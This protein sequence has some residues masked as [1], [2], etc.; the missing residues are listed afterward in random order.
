MSAARLIDYIASQNDR[1][2]G[3]PWSWNVAVIG[4][5]HGR[6]S[7]DSLGSA[8]KVKTII[9][10]RLKLTGANDADIK[11]LMTRSDATVDLSNRS[12]LMGL[13]WA[14]IK[15]ARSSEYPDGRPLLLLYPIDRESP[16]Q[17][18]KSNRERLNAVSNVLGIG[19][20]FPEAAIPAAVSYVRAPI[21]ASRYEEAEYQEEELDA[22]SS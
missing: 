1:G 15:R 10:A 22:E 13:D 2:N 7:E 11:A 9:R 16:P 5:E 8:G 18:N 14:D 3:S 12:T 19:I 4:A 21:D 6:P 20:V 17:R